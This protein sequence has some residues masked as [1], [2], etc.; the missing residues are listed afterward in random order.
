[1]RDH[2]LTTVIWFDCNRAV[3]AGGWATTL[4]LGTTALSAGWFA[5][6]SAYF[7]L[8]IDHRTSFG[9]GRCCCRRTTVVLICSGLRLESHARASIV[10]LKVVR[11]G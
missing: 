10:A 4:C 8:R 6:A 7:E 3:V 11:S 5:P 9:L 1:M 2:T